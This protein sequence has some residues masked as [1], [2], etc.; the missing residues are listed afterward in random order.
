MP[1]ARIIARKLHAGRDVVEAGK[2]I[3]KRTEGDRYVSLAAEYVVA[4]K[5]ELEIF[6]WLEAGLLSEHIRPHGKLMPR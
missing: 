2:A 1:C 6:G 3:P 4:S 5:S